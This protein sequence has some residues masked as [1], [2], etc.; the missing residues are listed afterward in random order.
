VLYGSPQQKITIR[1]CIRI[2]S[3][4]G[5][6]E[7]YSTQVVNGKWLP[8]YHLGSQLTMLSWG[9]G[10]HWLSFSFLVEKT[11]AI[12]LPAWLDSTRLDSTWRCIKS[13][14]RSPSNWPWSHGPW[15]NYSFPALPRG[16]SSTNC[17][18]MWPQK[19]PGHQAS[20]LSQVRISKFF[21]G[22]QYCRSSLDIM[23]RNW[24]LMFLDFFYNIKF[25][26]EIIYKIN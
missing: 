10:W 5:S 18:A 3:P 26:Y 23:C 25:N 24:S 22:I 21:N 6:S 19:A 2:P 13:E 14:L 9:N 7:G 12:M 17:F 1:K 8:K 11:N 4:A 16:A 20:Q 15:L